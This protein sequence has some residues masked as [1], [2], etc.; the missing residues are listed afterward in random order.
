MCI[1]KKLA[2][3]ESSDACRS[4]L[5]QNISILWFTIIEKESQLTL[6]QKDVALP[7]VL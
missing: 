2:E 5:K 6:R 4:W 3:Q 1:S 7:I